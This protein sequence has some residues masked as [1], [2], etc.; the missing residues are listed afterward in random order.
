MER[1]GDVGEGGHVMGKG[2]WGLETGWGVSMFIVAPAL[3]V[4]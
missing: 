2:C 4:E 3:P 1:R